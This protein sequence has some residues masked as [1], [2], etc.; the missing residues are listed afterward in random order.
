MAE[1]RSNHDEW[2]LHKEEIH[3]LYMEDGR[4]LSDVAALMKARHGF[5][6]TY[7]L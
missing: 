6:R 2:N 4:K 5:K 7:A 3:K 1:R